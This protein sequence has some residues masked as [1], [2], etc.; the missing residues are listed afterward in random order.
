M[1][2][3]QQRAR[4]VAAAAIREAALVKNHPPDLINV[5]LERLVEASLELP[6]FSTLDEMAAFTGRPLPARLTIVRLCEPRGPG[7]AR[8]CVAVL[9]HAAFSLSHLIV[10]DWRL[11]SGDVAC[12]AM[13]GRRCL[14]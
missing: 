4:A 14:S 11:V 2:Y 12:A 9:S 13:D 8:A 3:D 6:A 7:P 5:A 10:A 1:T